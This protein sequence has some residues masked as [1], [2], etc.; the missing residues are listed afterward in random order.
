MQIGSHPPLWISGNTCYSQSQSYIALCM[1]CWCWPKSFPWTGK[2]NKRIN[3][4]QILIWNNKKKL[5]GKGFKNDNLAL[6]SEVKTWEANAVLDEYGEVLH[7]HHGV[8]KQGKRNDPF[9][10]AFTQLF[11]CSLTCRLTAG[12]RQSLQGTILWSHKFCG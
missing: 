8:S 10:Q 4:M 3:D 11:I 1:N 5:L 9:R 2:R 6:L 7:L 12:S